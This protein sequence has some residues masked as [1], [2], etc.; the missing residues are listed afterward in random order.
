MPWKPEYAER[1]KQRA[2]A[3][4]EYRAKRNEQAKPKDADERRSYMRDYNAA[5]RERIAEQRREKAAERN[6]RRRER[7]AEDAAHRETCKASAR[8]RCKDARREARLRAEYGIN[9]ERYEAML[10]QQGGGCAI[11]GVPQGSRRGERLAVDHCH[12]SGRVRGLLCANCN[13]G[14]GLLED[15]P[16]RLRRAAEYLDGR[17]SVVG[18]LV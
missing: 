12:H 18:C 15:R 17:S 10:T 4:P 11:C 9:A 1:R 6:A 8:G 7:Y 2:A 3:D 5:N 13:R 14:I 16:E